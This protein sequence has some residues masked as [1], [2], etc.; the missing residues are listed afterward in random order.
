MSAELRPERLTPELVVAHFERLLCH[1]IR[2]FKVTESVEDCLQQVLLA[3]MTPSE[4]L[5]NS[6]LDRY[7]PSRGTAMHY[8]LM[9]CTQQMMKLHSR[10]QTRR[11]ILADPAS[12][13]Y[14]DAEFEDVA[15]PDLVKESEIADPSWS[16]ESC[17]A[18]IQGPDDLRRFLLGTRHAVAHSTSPSGEPRS[19]LYMLELLLWGGLT[20][21]EI[22]TRLSITTSEVHRRFK[23]L[24][25]EPRLQ[26]LFLSAA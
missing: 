8:V 21:A 16:L 15:N 11:H 9:F 1:R 26:A 12:L 4:K 5:G 24:R 23:G 7:D 20:I 19:T 14:D 25:N 10:E 2:Q 6:Y 3:M 13:V 18:T 22:A 17:E